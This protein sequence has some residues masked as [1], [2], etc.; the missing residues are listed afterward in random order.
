M[1]IYKKIS[2]CYYG[3]FYSRPIGVN[4]EGGDSPFRRYSLSI[5]NKFD[6]NNNV[7]HNQA[8]NSAF[9]QC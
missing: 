4:G 2:L 1:G 9:D 3:P 8:L 6:G 5:K 7:D